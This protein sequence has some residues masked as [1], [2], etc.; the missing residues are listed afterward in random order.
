VG[1]TSGQ[2]IIPREAVS[3]ALINRIV[4][5]G[6]LPGLE[7]AI[8]E[9]GKLSEQEPSPEEEAAA[10]A[11]TNPQGGDP[12]QTGTKPQQTGDAAPRT[13]YVSRKVLNGA[14]I[15]AWAKGQ[16]FTSTLPASD[17][18]VTITFSRT[19]VD[20]MEMGSSWEDKV[21]IPE[22]GARLMEQFGEATVLLFASN[23]LKY[24]HNE[25]V[26]MGAR[27]DHPEFQPHITISYEGAPADLSKVEPYQGEI[28]LG[29]EL[30]AEVKDD[31]QA[32]LKEE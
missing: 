5:D 7:T 31:W 4:E 18:H 30:F 29:P 21:T 14:D 13:L 9:Y 24:R 23:M 3:D 8:E 26:D 32:G 12:A 22:G 19:P 1:S 2:E 11:L 17:L 20:W 27:W 28:V 6:N 25:M 16:G 10:L 15:I